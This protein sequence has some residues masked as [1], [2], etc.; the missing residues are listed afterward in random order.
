MN[1]IYIYFF[2]YYKD[3]YR[4]TYK[5]EIVDKD[6]HRGKLKRFGVATIVDHGEVRQCSIEPRAISST[7]R[8]SLSLFGHLFPFLILSLFLFLTHSL[9]LPLFHPS[10]TSSKIILPFDHS[11]SSIVNVILTFWYVETIGKLTRNGIIVEPCSRKRKT[12][13]NDNGQRHYERI[14]EKHLRWH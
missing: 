10:W 1:N 8:L 2:N 11:S 14:F 3:I 13:K 4:N 6:R 5:V 7:Y 12:K 9:F